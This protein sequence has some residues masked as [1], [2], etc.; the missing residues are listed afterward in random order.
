VSDPSARKNRARRLPPVQRR[1]QLLDRALELLAQSGPAAVTMQAV[2]RAAGVARPVVYDFFADRAALLSALLAR[3]E[4]RALTDVLGVA[5]RL[6]L[7]SPLGADF[8]ADFCADFG[9]DFGASLTTAL[10]AFL[11]VVQGRPST[12]RALLASPTGLP[13][14]VAARLE[15]ARQAA[16]EVVESSV[17]A[18]LGARIAE[19]DTEVIS[20]AVIAAGEM[21]ARLVLTAPEKFPPARFT[22]FTSALFGALARIPATAAPR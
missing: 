14:E 11:E 8:G 3:E 7:G 16:L 12:W 18:S 2:A 4:S 5:P 9:A 20:R 1:E 22:T 19:L 17:R 13:A 10:Q 6:L 15:R 21:A